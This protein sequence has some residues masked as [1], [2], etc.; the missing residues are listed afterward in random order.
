[1]ETFVV[2]VAAWR[3]HGEESGDGVT[4]WDVE[5]K[6]LHCR[7]QKYEEV[8]WWKAQNESVLQFLV[9]EFRT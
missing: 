1:M 2:V 6:S 7:E 3:R 9:W 8:E 5:M 4:F